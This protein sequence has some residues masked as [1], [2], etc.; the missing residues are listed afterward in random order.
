MHK[1]IHAFIT[2]NGQTD[3][4]VVGTVA[5]AASAG[6]LHEM[7]S[8]ACIHQMIISIRGY[9]EGRIAMISTTGRRDSTLFCRIWVPA[10]C[11]ERAPWVMN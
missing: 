11:E 3:L 2:T 1:K 10:E 9:D 7:N 6:A 5:E 8:S 4:C